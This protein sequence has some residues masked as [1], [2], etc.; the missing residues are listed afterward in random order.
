V[1]EV[2]RNICV[3]GSRVHVVRP[4]LGTLCVVTPPSNDVEV[5]ER[6]K[7]FFFVYCLFFCELIDLN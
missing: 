7:T 2:E 6:S 1:V 5:D 3:G 4:T